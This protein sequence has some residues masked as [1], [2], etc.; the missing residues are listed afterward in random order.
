MVCDDRRRVD[1]EDWYG[2]LIEDHP[3]QKLT[4]PL[5]RILPETTCTVD[6][7]P[8]YTSRFFGLD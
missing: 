1:L 3:E 7:I 4:V 5:R 8:E 2:H 6:S